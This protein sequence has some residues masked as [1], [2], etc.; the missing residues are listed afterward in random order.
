[1]FCAAA[2]WAQEASEVYLVRSV[3]GEELELENEAVVAFSARAGSFLVLSSEGPSASFSGVGL[4]SRL[5][6]VSDR[7]SL[8]A[9]IRNPLNATLDHRGNRLLA[10][11]DGGVAS[12]GAGATGGVDPDERWTY[13]SE[14]LEVENPSGLTS[15]PVSGR[16]YVLDGS[17]PRVVTLA[18]VAGG[19][20]VAVGTM[21][22]GQSGLGALSGLAFEPSSGHLYSLSA[23]GDRLYAVTPSGVVAGSWDV[24]RL[25]LGN[26]RGMFFA[27]SADATD[28][29]SIWNLYIS[30][31]TS[32]ARVRRRAAFGPPTGSEPSS[33]TDLLEISMTAPPAPM[34]IASKGTLVQT[35]LSQNFSPPSPDSSGVT[36]DSHRGQLMMSDGE[37]NEMNI[38]DGANVWEFTTTG[39]VMNFWNTLSFSDEPTGIAFNPNN[40]HLFF[41]DDTG[42]RSVYELNPG[43]DELYRTSDDI[44]TSFKTGDYGST[45]PEGV[46]IDPVA[47]VLYVVDGVNREVYRVHPGPNGLFDGVTSDDQVTHWDTLGDGLDDPEGIA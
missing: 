22:L 36:W 21:D 38:Y 37:V 7:V 3:P 15:D 42:S 17:G 6:A 12:L 20:L 29:P 43:P 1:M 46:T 9:T 4:A 30:R 44:V 23:G 33:R 18:P 41:S 45:D 19:G 28:D 40:L 2:G 16:V 26:V 35:I 27:P 8:R 14:R 39:S 24:S 32:R 10:I 11:V 5:G 25:R 13:V 31:E 47:G 34:A